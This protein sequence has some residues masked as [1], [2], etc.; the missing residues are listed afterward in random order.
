MIPYYTCYSHYLEILSWV[1]GEGSGLITGKELWWS[2][3][4]SRPRDKWLA[5]LCCGSALLPSC[6]FIFRSVVSRICSNKFF[7][8][9]FSIQ[10]LLLNTYFAT[11]S[12][13]WKNL[14]S[15]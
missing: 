10:E 11:M 1:V 13:W 15:V 14:D 7:V 5:V 9:F 2:A 6:G 4:L 3:Q 8:I 12:L